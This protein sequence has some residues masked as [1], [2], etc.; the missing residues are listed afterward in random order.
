MPNWCSTS[1][2]LVGPKRSVNAAYRAFKRV[3]DTPHKDQTDICSYLSHSN[4]LGYVVTMI[5]RTSWDRIDC[6]GTFAEL[7]VAPVKDNLHGLRIYTE[8]A[9][10]PCT[11]L[12]ERV[13]AK[14]RLSLNF[15]AEEPGCIYYE[16]RNPDGV[17]A[18]NYVF[19]DDNGELETGYF[20]TMDDFIKEH[21]E[22]LDIKPGAT[23]EEAAA[24]LKN[25][26]HHFLYRFDGC[27]DPT[28]P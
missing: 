12:M 13:A 24:I 2:T 7:S 1:Y 27:D 20:D 25:D 14:Y 9:W 8:T 19:Y 28:R 5:L 18:T 17:Y 23:F 26:E 15:S 22:K 4:W 16:K 3:E 6:R 10:G 21:G 11:A